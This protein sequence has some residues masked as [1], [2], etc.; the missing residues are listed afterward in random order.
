MSHVYLY[1][2]LFQRFNFQKARRSGSFLYDSRLLELQSCIRL[3]AETQ[4]V[5]QL[6]GHA[7]VLQSE[8]S[9]AK[10]RIKEALLW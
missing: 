9:K 1:L 7:E 10:L 6:T 5:F 2:I 3:E 8:L 4:P